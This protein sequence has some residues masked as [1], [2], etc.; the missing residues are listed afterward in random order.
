MKMR[1]FVG[2]GFLAMYA[3]YALSAQAVAGT[4]TKTI[5]MSAQIVPGSSVSVYLH[6]GEVLTATRSDGAAAP[7]PLPGVALTT[8]SFETKP[9][10]RIVK[11]VTLD[12]NRHLL[13]IDF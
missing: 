13:T 7:V 1:F 3:M 11:R 4:A 9:S 5:Q 8:I 2:V 12:K 10:W 6:G